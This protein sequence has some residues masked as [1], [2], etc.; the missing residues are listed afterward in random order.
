MN[1]VAKLCGVGG[2]MSERWAE[3]EVWG[4]TARQRQM[5]W[6]CSIDPS[7]SDQC[8]HC[9][10]ATCPLPVLH[11][12]P[13]A[14]WRDF[15]PPSQ[16][17]TS[18]WGAKGETKRQ[19]GNAGFPRIIIQQVCQ[20]NLE[21]IS[22]CRNVTF[23][24]QSKFGQIL[25]LFRIS[26]KSCS[27]IYICFIFPG[28]CI[29]AVICPR[30]FLAKYIKWRKKKKIEKKQWQIKKLCRN[31]ETLGLYI[32]FL[33]ASSPLGGNNP[34][35]GEVSSEHSLDIRNFGC[36]LNRV[37]ETELFHLCHAQ[38]TGSMSPSLPAKDR[39]NKC[40]CGWKN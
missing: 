38:R 12:A 5:L 36:R 26:L 4:W 33:E 25:I 11:M 35:S 20:G 19:E 27:R 7:P 24:L 13:H 3:K 28:F 14:F 32:T 31:Y 10:V 23:L 9:A 17:Q 8:D 18:L 30:S 40:L 22:S 29:L 37:L 34:P 21:D 6:L 2:E 16:P 39:G 15:N 1:Q